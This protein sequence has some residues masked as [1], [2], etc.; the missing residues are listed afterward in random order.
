MAEKF[1]HSNG[2]EFES[3]DAFYKA[4]ADYW[5]KNPKAQPKAVAC[6]NLIMKREFAEKILKGEK[7]L[8]FRAYTQHYV[9]RLIDKDVDNYL[10]DHEGKEDDDLHTFAEVVRP[11]LKIHFHNYSNSWHLDV[12]CTNNF[13]M[14]IA[15]PWV[16][17]IQDTF[18]CH[19]MDEMLADLEKRKAKDRPLFFV[20]ALGKVL[21]T[22]LNV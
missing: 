20:F 17:N 22:D 11:V 10:A 2:R 9:D 14:P 12:E 6:L 3:L 13:I 4:Q 15:E 5:Q 7:K 1:I 8:E 18:G 19:E 16:K 21:D